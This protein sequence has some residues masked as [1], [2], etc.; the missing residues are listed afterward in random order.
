VFDEQKINRKRSE[1]EDHQQMPEEE[2]G[3]KIPAKRECPRQFASFDLI[4]FLPLLDEWWR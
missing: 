2:E 1:N 3:K 4:P